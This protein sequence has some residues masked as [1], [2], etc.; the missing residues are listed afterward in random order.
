[1][2]SR[3]VLFP[4]KG[5]PADGILF[6]MAINAVDS[7]GIHSKEFMF[8]SDLK[9]EF[10]SFNLSFLHINCVSTTLLVKGIKGTGQF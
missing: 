1:L 6:L 7:G 10:L 2:S 3:I 4:A 5:N 8:E 9:L